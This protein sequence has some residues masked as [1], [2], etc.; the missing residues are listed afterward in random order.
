MRNFKLAV[1]CIL[2]FHHNSYGQGIFIDINTLPIIPAKLVGNNE[3]ARV[4]AQTAFFIQSGV[5]SKIDMVKDT[6]NKKANK[7]KDTVILFVDNNTP[8]NSKK[9][10]IVVGAGHAILVERRFRVTVPS[11]WMRR[12]SHTFYW[13]PDQYRIEM[14]VHF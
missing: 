1:L 13:E 11:P 14:N 9:I 12:T 8:L 2:L 5:T 7:T 6:I 3:E 10:L 4:K